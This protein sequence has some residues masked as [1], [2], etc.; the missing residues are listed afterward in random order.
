MKAL[1]TVLSMV[2]FGFSASAL[3]GGD[4]FKVGIHDTKIVID[5]GHYSHKKD[6]HH[7]KHY[8]NGYSKKK[9]YRKKHYHKHS[10]HDYSY[11][12]SH[13]HYHGDY[14]K[15]HHYVPD[16]YIDH[17]ETQA[18]HCWPVQKKGYWKGRK[19][20]IGGQMCRDGGG[21]TYVVPASRYLIK[22]RG[23]YK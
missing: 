18:S 15:H 22:Y 9:Y 8:K 12:Y 23:K 21:Y 10:S 4:K 14:A 20:L 17:H 13:P 3:A 11:D 7:N 19:A 2:L 16:Y 6:Y 1:V 5:L